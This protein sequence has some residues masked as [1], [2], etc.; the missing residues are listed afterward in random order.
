MTFH[1]SYGDVSVAQ[2]RAYKRYNVS[3]SDHDDLYRVF[4]DNHAAI[5]VVVTDP[6]YMTGLSFSFYKFAKAR[7]NYS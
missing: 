7:L 1:E 4:G 5:V 6:N 2:L 3:P